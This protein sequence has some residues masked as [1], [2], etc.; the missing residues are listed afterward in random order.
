MGAAEH[1][2]GDPELRA[3][4]HE[5]AALLAPPH[6]RARGE[7][8]VV[9]GAGVAGLFAARAL[10]H[11]GCDVLVV[12]ARSRVG[13][14]LHTDLELGVDVQLGA[15]WIHGSAGCDVFLPVL[16]AAGVRTV[17]WQSERATLIAQDGHRLGSV[18]MLREAWSVWRLLGRLAQHDEPPQATLAAMLDRDTGRHGAD[19]DPV[20]RYLQRGCVEP[21]D[22]LDRVAQAAADDVDRRG[23][24]DEVPIGGWSRLLAALR[25]GLDIVTGAPVDAIVHRPGGV[26]VIAGTRSFSAR[27][28]VLAVPLGVLRASAIVLD[29]PL[30]APVAAAIAAALPRR[31]DKI[32][33]RFPE[34][35]W[36]QDVSALVALADASHAGTTFLVPSATAPVLVACV[37]G[38]HAAQLARAPDDEVSATL[39]AQLSTVLRRPV[40]R[41]RLL[42]RAGWLTD[43]WTR[44]GYRLRD[45]QD[46]RT[47]AEPAGPR[48]WLAGEL[49][50]GKLVGTAPGAAI[51]G[52][53]AARRV[54]AGLDVAA[55]SIAT[56]PSDSTSHG[57]SRK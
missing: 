35:C 33:C 21:D 54:L 19:V 40:P 45:R 13:G 5:L 52:L 20:I 55:L 50:G 14:Q 41:P 46:A 1:T 57:E 36:P 2:R 26:T 28:C 43:P 39:A 18:G 4:G 44:G 56:R 9:V 17:P 32:A 30:P 38:K 34:R 10:R 51:S 23:A 42:R 24:R 48:L 29:P 22:D 49:V 7:R 15:G 37:A 11:A 16:A 53:R 12:E 3:L 25:D 47:L 27:A 8:I 6:G 31:L